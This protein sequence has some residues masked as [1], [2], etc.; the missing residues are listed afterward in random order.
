MRVNILPLILCVCLSLGMTTAGTQNAQ[1][2]NFSNTPDSFADIV[3]D[4]LPAVVNISSTQKVEPMPE[5][6]DM[7]DMP[8]LPEG[9]PFEHFF[10]EFMQRQGPHGMRMMPEASLGS[11]FVIDAENGYVITNSHVVRDAEE[12]RVTF[13]DDET[14]DAE[15][16]GHDEKTD[17]AVLKVT[18]DKKLTAVDFGNSDVLRVGDWIVAI[19]NPFGPRW[20]SHRR[21]R[22]RPSPRH[23]RR[24]I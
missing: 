19:G 23:Q 22:L 21:D 16:I 15:I 5:L 12:V 14:L 7:P 18:T 17:L 20:N 4:L 3:E 10:E 6:Q 8:E 24:P 2:R 13:H 11:G 1:A 9:S